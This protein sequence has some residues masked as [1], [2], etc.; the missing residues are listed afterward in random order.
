T[1]EN[2]ARLA[3]R[4]NGRA[5]AFD[6]LADEL[7]TAGVVICVTSSPETVIDRATLE[8]VTT[9]HELVAI[10]IALPRDV[11]PSARDLPN[12]ELRDM[13]DLRPIIDLGPERPRAA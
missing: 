9:D 1:Y 6:A 13:A 3:E 2:G 11:D 10:D 12:L 7:R 8:R 4:F 5:V